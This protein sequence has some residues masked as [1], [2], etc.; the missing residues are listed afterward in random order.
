MLD[1]LPFL[2]VL[3]VVSAFIQADSV[4]TIFYMII[5]AFFGGIWWNKAAI[6]RIKIDRSFEDHAFNSQNIPIELII[7]NTSILPIIWLEL[8]ESM[9][10]Q[11]SSGSKIQPCCIS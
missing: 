9:P 3:M 10:V 8:H 1:Y 2:I 11:L 5:G 7:K 4:M 6:K